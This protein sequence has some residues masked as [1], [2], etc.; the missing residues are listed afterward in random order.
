MGLKIV[1]IAMVII[2]IYFSIFL[3][4]CEADNGSVVGYE[5]ILKDGRSIKTETCWEDGDKIFYKKYGSTIGFSKS[6]IKEVKEIMSKPDS[7]I[8]QNNSAMSQS[9]TIFSCDRYDCPSNGRC[10]ARTYTLE[11]AKI[12][13]A[14]WE[15]ARY[16][17]PSSLIS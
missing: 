6:K 9:T 13:I 7:K 4:Y 11:E 14:Y 3:G 15:K 12:E 16:I 1:K 8:M 10:D 5:I 17:I 2:F